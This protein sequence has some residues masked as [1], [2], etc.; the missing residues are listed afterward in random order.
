MR[1]LNDS[2]AH[3]GLTIT[4]ASILGLLAGR[5]E[6]SLSELVRLEAINPTM[7]SRVVGKIESA[8]LPTAPARVGETLGPAQHQT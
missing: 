7:L 3:E 6:V 2:A 4:Q 5:G 8:G 1:R